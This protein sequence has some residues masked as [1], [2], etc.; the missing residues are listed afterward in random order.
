MSGRLIVVQPAE[1]TSSMTRHRKSGSLRVASSAEN[2]T[3]SVYL[4]GA[5]HGGDRGVEARLARHAQLALEVQVGRG[6]EDVDAAAAGGGERRAGPVDVG[7]AAAREPGNDRAVDERGNHAHRFGIRLGRDREPGLDDVDAERR[8]L[9][10]QLQ[11]LVDPHR[12]AR[13][14]L[15]VAQGRVEDREP[16]GRHGSSADRCTH[17]A[18]PRPIYSF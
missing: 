10:G 18:A 3:S 7:G 17:P 16:V 5:V 2:W 4:P 15:A 9:P 6:D 1:I 13:S 12:E 11:L 14:L 8:E